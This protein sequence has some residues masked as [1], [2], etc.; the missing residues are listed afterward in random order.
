MLK[1]SFGFGLGLLLIVVSCGKTAE[2]NNNKTPDQV[3]ASRDQMLKSINTFRASTNLKPLVLSSVMNE[4]VQAHADDMAQG[5]SPYSQDGLSVRCSRSR[6]RVPGTGT[7]CVQILERF[8]SV[9]QT[10]VENWKLNLVYRS[11]LLNSSFGHIGIGYG[12]DKEG[13]SY[14]SVIMLER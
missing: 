13:R 8:V 10:V 9:P 7:G 1:Q 6:E 2:E 3:E 11:Y 12:L 14:W 5:R 4:E